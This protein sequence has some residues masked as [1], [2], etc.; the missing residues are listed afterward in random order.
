MYIRFEKKRNPNEGRI[1]LLYIF[2]YIFIGTLPV[3]FCVRFGE[4]YRFN[5]FAPPPTQSAR[6][7]TIIYF[8]HVRDV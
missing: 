5:I 2:V 3:A 8:L 7:A 1:I 6:A 4:Y